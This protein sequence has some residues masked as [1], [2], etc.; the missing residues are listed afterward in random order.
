[1]SNIIEFPILNFE[2]LKKTSENNWFIIPAILFAVI[3]IFI[4]I[5]VFKKASSV[6]KDLSG[7]NEQ[8]EVISEKAK[9]VYKKSYVPNYAI[10]KM[11]FVIFEKENGERIE[12]AIKDSEKYKLMLEG[13]SGILKHIGK[14][15]ISFYR[16]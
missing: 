14:K 5:P 10:E 3:F 1:M 11:N 8:G 9:I 12:M 16:Q 13:D 15:F 6:T 4:I 7:E 2:V